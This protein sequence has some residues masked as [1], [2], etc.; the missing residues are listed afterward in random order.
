MK[1]AVKWTLMT[2]LITVALPGVSYAYTAEQ[3]QLCTG[4]AMRL[5]SSEIPDV[6]RVTA[7]MIQKKSQLSDGCRSVFHG[8][9]QV[10]YQ[11]GRPAKPISLV[12]KTIR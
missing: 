4:D 3:E 1:S 6:G 8:P 12:P 10:N 11:Q 7:C 5:C 2:A 9:T